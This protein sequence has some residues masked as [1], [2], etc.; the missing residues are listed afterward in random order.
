MRLPVC[1][2][3][4]FFAHSAFATTAPAA[5]DALHDAVRSFVEAQTHAL[6][7]GVSIEIPPR[8]PRT[9]LGECA[10]PEVFVPAGT[11]LWGKTRVGVRCSAPSNWLMYQSVTIRVSGHFLSSTR[12]IKTGEVVSDPDFK[13]EPGELTALPEDVLTAADELRGRRTRLAIAAGQPIRKDHL[14]RNVVFR[15]GEKVRIVVRGNGFSVSSEGTALVNGY[16]GEV[17]RVK[18]AA[19]K[20]VEGRARAAGYVE[21]TP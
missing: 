2:A 18:N 14:Q 7:A 13:L 16:D 8:D 5:K 15:Q 12:Q 3:L 11:R 17:V 10:A 6:G 20:A 1:F 21:L 4:A 19:G 9:R